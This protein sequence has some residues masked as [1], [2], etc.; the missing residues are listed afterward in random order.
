MALSRLI[1]A[2]T[3]SFAAFAAA[4]QTA[5]PWKPTR[6]IEIVNPAAP[7]GSVD[8]M[9][10]MLKKFIEDNRL[11]DVPVNVV[12][13]TGANGAIAL[14]HVNQAQGSGEMLFAI[15][16]T[17]LTI[18]L[19]GDSKLDWRDLTP[20]GILFKEFHVT[21]VNADSPLKTGRDLIERM[22]ADPSS[23]SFGFFGNP[24]NHLH[25]GAA[26]PFKAAGI[27]IRRMT[28]VPYRSG[29][30]AMVAAMGGHLD[31]ALVSAVNPAP[32]VQSGK[33]RVL[34][35]SSPARL[36]G[37]LKQ[38]P[39]WKELGV[40]VEYATAQGFAGPRG[41]PPAAVAFWEGVL[42][43]LAKDPEWQKTLDRSV[44]QGAY[45]TSAEMRRYYES[46]FSRLGAVLGELGL[47]KQ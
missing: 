18:R 47:V 33:M 13:K 3:L 2:A 21:A 36:D 7:G 20:V 37:Y 10:R 15:A 5:A 40:D 1:A 28:N 27:D 31:V 30:E 41:M 24:G 22:R 9:C 6:A 11:V 14:D 16:H 35:Q 8:L 23:L 17:F 43:K 39:T 19:T 12:Y 46:E 38:V 34:T 26:I 45:M 44:W 29:P 32:H 42:G 4:A 25:L